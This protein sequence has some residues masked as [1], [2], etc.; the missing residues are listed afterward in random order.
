[1]RTIHLEG[2]IEKLDQSVELKIDA[3]LSMAHLT[4]CNIL[5]T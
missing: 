2:K 4:N 5:H 1:M 3:K